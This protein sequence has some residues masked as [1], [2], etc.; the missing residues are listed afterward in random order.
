MEKIDLSIW[1]FL[2]NNFLIFMILQKNLHTVQA[3]AKVQL[4]FLPISI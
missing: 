2:L 3:N 4:I 1:N